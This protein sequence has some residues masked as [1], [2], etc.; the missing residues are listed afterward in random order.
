MEGMTTTR[1]DNEQGTKCNSSKAQKQT[2]CE[3]NK[4]MKA[5]T[6]NKNKTN[7]KNINKTTML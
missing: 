1:H 3:N 4:T 5:K 7:N 2:R 6:K